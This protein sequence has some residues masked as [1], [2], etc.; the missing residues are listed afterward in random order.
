MPLETLSPGAMVFG[1]EGAF[2]TGGAQPNADP[3]ALSGIQNAIVSAFNRGL[4]TNFNIHPNNWGSPPL[5]TSASANVAGGNL[6]PST[7]YYYVITATNADGETTTSLER[8]VL[9]STTNKQATLVWEPLSA[10]TQYNVYRSTTPGAGYQLV[11][12]V[13]NGVPN[14][15]G[16]TD[17]GDTP[18]SQAPPIFYAPGTTSNWYAAFA[19]LNATNNPTSGVSINGLAYGFAYDDQGGQSTDFTVPT[20]SQIIIDL[21]SW[22][23]SNPIPSPGPNPHPAPPSVPTSLTVL[24][25]PISQKHGAPQTVTF[26]VFTAHGHPFFGGTTVTVQLIG[27]KRQTY[28][29]NTDPTTGIGSLSIDATQ[30]GK[31]YL[32]FSLD[33]GSA[34]YSN[35]FKISKKPKDV[36]NSW[37]R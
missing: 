7:N 18:Q 10:P 23:K 14:A 4:A 13:P 3:V 2:K 24:T 30:K 35:L 31:Y 37:R 17:M 34:F 16:Y 19:H 8:Q 25:Q 33:D 1:N 5:F 21:E 32:K 22:G 6:A 12:Q 15:T 36:F 26:R 11:A 28:S 20:T 29:V 27:P 9:T